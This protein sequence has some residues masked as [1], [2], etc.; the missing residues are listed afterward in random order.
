[1]HINPDYVGKIAEFQGLPLKLT[2]CKPGDKKKFILSVRPCKVTGVYIMRYNENEYCATSEQV[3]NHLLTALEIARI[4]SYAPTHTIGIHVP[5]YPYIEQSVTDI[6]K[7]LAIF[8]I[9]MDNYF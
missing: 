2:I 1:M 5:F 7:V 4:S 3:K 6:D 8:K 9:A